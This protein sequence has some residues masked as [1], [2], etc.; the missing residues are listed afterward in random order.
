[1]QIKKLMVATNKKRG[2]DI[3]N[4]IIP[5][6]LWASDDLRTVAHYY[7]GCV[8]EI[9][10]KLLKTQRKEYIRNYDDTERYKNGY[11]WGT[12]EM[13]CPAGANWY[14]FS[15]EYIMKNLLSIREIYPDISKY[16]EDD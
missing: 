3:L 9:K 10:I 2:H 6:V 5:P 14:S 12:A 8:L 16:Q 1:M 4:G 7:G 15:R 11:T 13:L